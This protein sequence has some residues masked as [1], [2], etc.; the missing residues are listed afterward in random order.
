MLPDVIIHC[1]A[2]VSSGLDVVDKKTLFEGNVL[3]TD[4]IVKKFPSAKH[5]YF[6]TVSVYEQNDNIK[7]EVPS[8][9]NPNSGWDEAIPDPKIKSGWDK[10]QESLGLQPSLWDE[11]KDKQPVKGT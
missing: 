8:Y 11:P 7:T 1:H 4:K 10:V 6:S 5:I 9:R 3:A 2:A